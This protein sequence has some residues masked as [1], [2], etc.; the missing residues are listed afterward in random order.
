MDD[1]IRYIQSLT[2]SLKDFPFEFEAQSDDVY[3][4]QLKVLADSKFSLEANTLKSKPT[5][6]MGQ[7]WIIKSSYE[8]YFTNRVE[9]DTPFIVLIVEANENLENELFSRVQPVSPFIEFLA[10]DDYVVSDPSLIG[11]PFLIETWNEQPVLNEILDYSLG[12]FDIDQYI[13]FKS[14][15]DLTEQK[16]A[17]RKSEVDNTAFLRHS[18]LSYLKFLEER[19]T[20]DT[21]IIIN[22][23]QHVVKPA[24]FADEIK[25]NTHYAY[26]AKTGIDNSNKYFELEEKLASGD[27]KIRIKRNVED[28]ILSVYSD[29]E[30]VLK[31]NDNKVVVGTKAE[32]RMIFTMLN[33]GLYYLESTSLKSLIKIRF[34]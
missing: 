34:K 3:F 8:D 1:K 21:G 12:S 9:S 25:Y 6:R 22:I 11:F 16:T 33:P 13:S 18:I 19:Q 28:F 24:F 4:N 5:P 29:I 15:I 27:I 20:E 10:G 32:S 2:E 26:A 7:L 14:N 17:F 23:N 31:S 30:F